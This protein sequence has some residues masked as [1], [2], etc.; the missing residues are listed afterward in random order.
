MQTFPFRSGRWARI[1]LSVLGAHRGTATVDGDVVRIRMGLAGRADVPVAL[2][3]RV[4]TV[5]W[6]AWGGL[7]ARIAR[8]MVAYVARSGTLVVMELSETLKVKT[9]LSWRTT[10][11]A[12]GV[13]DPEGLIDAIFQ[14]RRLQRPGGNAPPPDEP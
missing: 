9:P 7:G 5:E 6:P 10:S 13:V 11:V 14:A 8:G 2:M 4:G 12:V 1:L 3:D